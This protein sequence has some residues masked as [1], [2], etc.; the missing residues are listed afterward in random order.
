MMNEE[1]KLERIS[2]FNK[3]VGGKLKAVRESMDITLGQLSRATGGRLSK[4]RISNYEQGIR[5]L[6]NDVAVILAY[7]L[8]TPVEELLCLK[9][10]KDYYDAQ[11][12][13][14]N[15]DD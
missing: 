6:P 13:E 10:L 12:G 15:Y 8:K 3:H 2:D 14:L 4:S 5:T 1:K 7:Y 9:E 11:L